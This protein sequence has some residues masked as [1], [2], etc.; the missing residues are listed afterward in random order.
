MNRTEHASIDPRFLQQGFRWADVVK[1]ERGTL[2]GN[3]HMYK[4]ATLLTLTGSP[5]HQNHSTD[6]PIHTTD[7]KANPV[8]PISTAL[9]RLSHAETTRR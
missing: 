1:E 3:I 7:Q 4:A 5:E 6:V 8:N 2:T 9:A